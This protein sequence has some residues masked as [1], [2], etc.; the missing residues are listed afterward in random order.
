MSRRSSRDNARQATLVGWNSH[1]RERINPSSI[2]ALKIRISVMKMPIDVRSRSR[3]SD[4]SN[5]R[6]SSAIHAARGEKIISAR[7]A[8]DFGEFPCS[9]PASESRCGRLLPTLLQEKPT[10]VRIPL[11]TAT[12]RKSTPSHQM[13]MVNTPSLKRVT[14]SNSRR[15]KIIGVDDP[16]R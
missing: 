5:C 13:V 15:C 10:T 4:I 14:A 2:A 8:L 11:D 1:R 9:S 16:W 12:L 6:Q 7:Q 3:W